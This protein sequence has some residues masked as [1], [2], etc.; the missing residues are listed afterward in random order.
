MRALFDLYG[1][2]AL[3]PLISAR[4]TLEDAPAAIQAVADRRVLGKIIVEIAPHQDA[5]IHPR[6]YRSEQA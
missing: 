4:H 5:G 6:N 2:G 3:K 1:E